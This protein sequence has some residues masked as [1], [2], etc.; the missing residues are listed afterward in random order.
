MKKD[1][2]QARHV[3]RDLFLTFARIGAFTF[4]GGW[5]MISIMEKEIVDRHGWMSKEE[6]LDQLAVAQSMPGILAVNISVAVGDKIR[7]G[8]GSICAALGTILPSFCIIL[9]IAIFLTPDMIK[10]NPV[11]SKVF[12]GI[13]PAVVALIIAPVLTTARSAGINWRTAWI[14]VSAALLIW[15][16]I[17]YIS[18]PILYV[19]LGALG[20]WLWY[21][22]GA[23]GMRKGGESR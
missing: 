9:A 14:P 12:M 4:G 2:V 16:G 23:A 18:N 15:S 5:A 7:G 22:R 19:I 1:G 11:L 8:A 10:S 3:L 20:G 17:P 21:G 6:F 13:R